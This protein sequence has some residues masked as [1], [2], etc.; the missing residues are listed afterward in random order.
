M[1][2]LVLKGLPGHEARPHL[3]GDTIG[4]ASSWVTDVYRRLPRDQDAREAVVINVGQF[5]LVT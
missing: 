2:Q 1:F 4:A 3:T 5:Q